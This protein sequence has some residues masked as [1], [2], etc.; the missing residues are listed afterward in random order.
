[1]L[2]PPLLPSPFPYSF[3]LLHPFLLSL[4]LLSPFPSL[5]PT[6]TSA[7]SMFWFAVSLLQM[8]GHRK[9]SEENYK[10]MFLIILKYIHIHEVL[11][12]ITFKVDCLNAGL[13]PAPFCLQWNVHTQYG[14]SE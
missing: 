14:M 2:Y 11:C 6:L 12:H 1:M 8:S 7:F 13:L 9:S 4:H 3:F 5:S 10:Y